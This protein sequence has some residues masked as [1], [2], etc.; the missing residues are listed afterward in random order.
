MKQRI[1]AIILTLAILEDGVHRSTWVQTV[2]VP[3]ERQTKEIGQSVFFLHSLTHPSSA[4]DVPGGS[5]AT[6]AAIT[7][8]R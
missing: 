7:L 4:S 2:A 5:L 8:G 3:T 6:R 1:Y